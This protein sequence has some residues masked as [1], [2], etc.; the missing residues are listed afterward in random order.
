MEARAPAPLRV[1]S[2]PAPPRDL[3]DLPFLL[4]LGLLPDPGHEAGAEHAGDAPRSRLERGPAASGGAP[5]QLGR[6]R[7]AV[8]GGLPPVP[9]G[10]VRGAGGV[11]VPIG[12]RLAEVAEA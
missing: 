11:R 7:G 2:T 1:T 3:R 5:A 9:V 4:S 10:G 6:K 8:R 12:G